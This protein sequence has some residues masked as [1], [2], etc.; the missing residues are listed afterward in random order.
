MLIESSGEGGKGKNSLATDSRLQLLVWL[1]RPM[2]LLDELEQSSA[3][4]LAASGPSRTPLGDSFSQMLSLEECLLSLLEVDP[5]N[6]RSGERALTMLLL[7]LLSLYVNLELEELLLS[8]TFHKVV[9]IC[10]KKRTHRFSD[11]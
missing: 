2:I 7:L 6:L 11:K 9:V 5:K 8:A 1:R 10:K 3:G 4:V